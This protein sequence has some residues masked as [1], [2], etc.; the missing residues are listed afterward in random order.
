MSDSKSGTTAVL[1][2]FRDEDSDISERSVSTV[3]LDQVLELEKIVKEGDW[4]AVMQAATWYTRLRPTRRAF[5]RWT[6][7][8]WTTRCPES[9]LPCSPTASPWSSPF[10]PPVDPEKRTEIELLL[11]HVMPD[12]VENMDE[13]LVQFSG[14]EKELIATLATMNEATLSAANERRSLSSSSGSG[15]HSRVLD[16]RG[17]RRR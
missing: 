6:T 9:R 16:E 12:E 3:E 5:R 10:P 7:S 2:A 11:R 1:S 17:H 8:Q 15:A 4:Q 14:R 13:V